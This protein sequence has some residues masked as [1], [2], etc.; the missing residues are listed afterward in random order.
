MGDP[1]TRGIPARPSDFKEPGNLG[2]PSPALASE[3]TEI[4]AA[5]KSHHKK[6]ETQPSGG[7]A[8]GAGNPPR[9]PAVWTPISAGAFLQAI[10]YLPAGL[11]GYDGWMLEESE[12]KSCAPLAAEIFQDLLPADAYWVKL[13]A[14]AGVMGGIE[15]N[16]MRKYKN[17]LAEQSKKNP[18]VK[19]P[20]NVPAPIPAA[21]PEAL[22]LP[23]FNP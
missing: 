14:F 7:S 20:P 19:P 15:I 12:L 5:R 13:L 8:V 10:H 21:N 23:P 18:P 3:L 4:R 16:K 2:G 9:P 22:K 11:T 6:T 1:E 17:W